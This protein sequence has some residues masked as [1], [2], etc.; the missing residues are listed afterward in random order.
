MSVRINYY[1]YEGV[2]STLD[3]W[4]SC[5]DVDG[6]APEPRRVIETYSPGKTPN[7]ECPAWRHKNSREFIIS[8]PREI[9]LH[10]DNENGAV[11]S[12][13]MT[14]DQINN[15][16]KVEDKEPPITTIQKMCPMVLCWTDAKRV[17]VEVKD[18][19]IT[20]RNNNFTLTNGWFNLSSWCRPISFG[21]NVCDPNEPVVIKRGD[22]LYKL[23]FYQ[24]DNLDQT[25][26]MVKAQPHT[27]L[28][29]DVYKR[30][31]VKHFQ[32]HL[33]DDLIFKDKEEKCPFGWLFND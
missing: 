7:W 3:A 10:I 24:E 11:G 32:S 12:P 13:S 19:P 33:A 31:K 18:H 23:A 30:M 6:V 9:I 29:L 26:K 14:N 27:E 22:P 17:W 4:D 16:V 28:L 8:A 1:Q 25:F 21:L 15:Y 5:I 2:H 20:S